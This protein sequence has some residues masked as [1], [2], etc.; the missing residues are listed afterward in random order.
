MQ[1]TGKTAHLEHIF[2]NNLHVDFVKSIF[3][4]NFSEV[5]HQ[6]RCLLVLASQYSS[7]EFTPYLTNEIKLSHTEIHI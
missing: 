6:T 4:D 2:Q 1:Q 7:D 3:E 5:S